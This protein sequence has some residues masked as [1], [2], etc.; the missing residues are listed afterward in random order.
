MTLLAF[1]L[2]SSS[3][4]LLGV[5]VVLLFIEG[6]ELSCLDRLCMDVQCKVCW[7]ETESKANE[8]KVAFYSHAPLITFL[9]SAKTFLWRDGNDVGL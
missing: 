1:L 2:C 5:F 4:D 3:F 8:R 7:F 9:T 6:E